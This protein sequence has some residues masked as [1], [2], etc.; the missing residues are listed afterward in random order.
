MSALIGLQAIEILD[1]RG[2]PTLEVKAILESGHMG[3]ASVPSGASCG[4]FEAYEKRDEET[5]FFG[6]GVQKAVRLV[7]HEIMD[8]L[9]GR[10]AL[11][12]ADID[13]LLLELDG[14]PQKKNLGGNTILAVSLAIARAASYELNLPL[15]RY[16]GGVSARRL[17]IP[18][19][20]ILNGGKHA[21][22]NID[23]Q[24]FMIIP[25]SAT[26]FS[27]ATE[28]VCHV[29]HAL[30][31]L[32]KEKNYPTNVGDEGGFAPCLQ[33][34]QHALDLLMQAISKAGLKPEK[35]IALALDCAA[36][37]FYQDNHYRLH[38][39]TR[40]L[41]SKEL[42]DYYIHLTQNY[43]IISIEDPM[44][45]TDIKGWEYLYS[46][47]PSFLKIVA[48]DL[49]VT[50]PERITRALQEKLA[51]AILIKPN[52]IGTLTQTLEAIRTTHHLGYHTIIS[53]RSGETE[54]PFIADLTVA[55]NAG[56]IKLGAPCRSERL[57][58]YNQLLRIEKMLGSEGFYT[59]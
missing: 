33:T 26:S 39:H 22:N 38:D 41:S 30:R 31:L 51:N 57:A 11:N 46:Q 29:Y 12:Q 56:Y 3:T 21:S 54:D 40:P 10:E 42:S 18:Y 28:M 1:S 9:S 23:I 49:T 19:V 35:D 32:L 45:E 8:L 4:M 15:Y 6:K 36:S 55:T 34:T 25:T 27:Q 53:H 24:E 37:E 13:Y 2:F 7:H 44:A 47:A 14:T 17:P 59:N 50:H 52:Q 48:D 43:P 16:I 5:R 58:K 20:N